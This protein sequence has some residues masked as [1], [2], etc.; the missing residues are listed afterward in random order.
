MSFLIYILVLGLVARWVVA[1][2]QGGMQR[3]EIAARDAQLRRLR[4]EVDTLHSEVRRLAD[5]HS[6]MV[7]LL[8]EGDRSRR[9]LPPREH[10]PDPDPN[11]ETP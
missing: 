5:E 7:R 4:E 3:G 9:D 2:W 11:P 8:T 6:F 1:S 10:S